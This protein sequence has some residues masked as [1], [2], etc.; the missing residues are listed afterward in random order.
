MNDEH[1][2]TE[3]KPTAEMTPDDIQ[4]IR[5]ELKK[6]ATEL[7][8]SGCWAIA[9]FPGTRYLG[10][11][12][13]LFYEGGYIEDPSK[14]DILSHFPFYIA[15]NPVWDYLIQ[16]APNPEAAGMLSKIPTVLPIDMTSHNTPQ[17]L[18]CPHLLFLQDVQEDDLEMYKG[19]VSNGIVIT[20]KSEF[21][22]MAPGQQQSGPRIITP[23]QAARDL[24]QARAAAGMPQ[25]PGM[26]GMPGMPGMPGQRRR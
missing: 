10:K 25:I 5:S 13:K 1:N 12:Y 15:M 23:D 14:D 24:A 8:S 11:I 19:L 4:K 2:H 18:Y 22:E 3:D 21:I 16:L 7:M 26:R 9:M 6:E 20:R 17:H